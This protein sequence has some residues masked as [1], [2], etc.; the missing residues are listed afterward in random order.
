[1]KNSCKHTA[2]RFRQVG[3]CPEE[4]RSAPGRICIT[5]KCSKC[6]AK[7]SINTEGPCEYSPW[8]PSNAEVEKKLADQ[9]HLEK[10]LAKTT[11]KLENAWSA[12]GFPPDHCG[13]LAEE[14]SRCRDEGRAHFHDV[15]RLQ[16]ELGKLEKESDA[17]EFAAKL[18]LSQFEVTANSQE[19]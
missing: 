11:E 8:G 3:R 6:G 17:W 4:N 7:R 19:P 2:S 13:D 5:E 16:N 10:K 14:I 1:M 18:I 15:A 9:A 12:L